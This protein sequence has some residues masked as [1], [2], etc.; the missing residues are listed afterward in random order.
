[1]TNEVNRRSFLGLAAPLAVTGSF[2]ALVPSVLVANAEQPPAEW[3]QKIPTEPGY[4]WVYSPSRDGEESDMMYVLE[5]YDEDGGKDFHVWGGGRSIGGIRGYLNDRKRDGET[6]YWC[7][8]TH[9][10]TFDLTKFA[11]KKDKK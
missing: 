10:P 2:T 9:V 6:I 3:S 5:L 11:K 1:M 7:P 8:A 4:Y